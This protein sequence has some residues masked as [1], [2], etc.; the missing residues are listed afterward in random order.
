MGKSRRGKEG[1]KP[2]RSYSEYNADN[3]LISPREVEVA[4]NGDAPSSAQLDGE[5]DEEQ[6]A[7]GRGS[8]ASEEPL[9]D[10]HALYQKAVQVSN[11]L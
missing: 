11:K 10:K 5:S 8:A 6:G 3:Y 9:L 2:H 4:K 1:S 7:E